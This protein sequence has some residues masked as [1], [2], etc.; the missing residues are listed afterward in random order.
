MGRGNS[1]GGGQ[2]S[3]GYLFGSGEAPK[4]AANKPAAPTNEGQ[5]VNNAPAS[6]PTVAPPQP[7]DVSKQIP[8]GINSTS[9]NNYLRADG[10]NTGNFITVRF[11]H[12]SLLFPLCSICMDSLLYEELRILWKGTIYMDGVDFVFE[13][14]ALRIFGHK[15]LFAPRDQLFNETRQHFFYV[16]LP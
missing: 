9:T 7:V 14:K 8:A 6:K 15:I 2:S 12:L 10:Q 3:L 1:S 13:V 4:P 11:F 16:L 5:A